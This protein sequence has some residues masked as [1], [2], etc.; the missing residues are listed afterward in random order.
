MSGAD[1][2]FSVSP[3]NIKRLDWRHLNLN[4]Y[5]VQLVEGFNVEVHHRQHHHSV[6]DKRWLYGAV[7]FE[8]RLID[9]CELPI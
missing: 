2:V 9:H 5:L 1:E 8:Q 3:S 7:H 4:I 6:T